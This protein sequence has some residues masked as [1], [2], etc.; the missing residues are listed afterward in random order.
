MAI[1]DFGIDAFRRHLLRE[2][3]SQNTARLYGAVLH[4]VLREAAIDRWTVDVAA[5]IR[6]VQGVKTSYRRQIGSAWAAYRRF[7]VAHGHGFPP[8]PEVSAAVVATRTPDIESALGFISVKA[9]D[10]MSLSWS[11]VVWRAGGMVYYY[12]P[13]RCRLVPSLE[14]DTM[15]WLVLWRQAL[16]ERR[17][18]AEDIKIVQ[19][20]NVRSAITSVQA[21]VVA[22][23]LS[24][25][26]GRLQRNAKNRALPMLRYDPDAIAAEWP[27]PSLVMSSGH[28]PLP[29]QVA[30]QPLAEIERRVEIM[31]QRDLSRGRP[32]DDGAMAYYR[33]AAKQ[34]IEAEQLALVDDI[35][36]YVPPRPPPQ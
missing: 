36:P 9:P 30:A 22:P 2:G 14:E 31:K 29:V 20:E 23:H 21:H 7:A 28:T 24:P 26:I 17:V 10:L 34:E 13:V 5:A 33:D 6:Y 35:K 3:L 4:P 27:L 32:V 12:E 18:H 16:L 8:F 19:V 11:H 25:R 1:D 15:C